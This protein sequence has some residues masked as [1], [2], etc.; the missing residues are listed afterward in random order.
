MFEWLKTEFQWMYWTWPSVTFF[1]ILFIAI[2]CLTVWDALSPCIKR[3]GFLPFATTRGDRFF[4]GIICT[5]GI[6]LLWL[7][8]VGNHVFIGA[9][10]LSVIW[11]IVLGRW[12]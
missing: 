11:N 2:A 4:I 12:G 10:M 5:I 6:C 3:K 9:I 7:G 8:F 1:L